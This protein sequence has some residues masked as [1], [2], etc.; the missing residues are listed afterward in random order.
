MLVPVLSVIMFQYR[1]NDAGTNVV[2][3]FQWC[4]RE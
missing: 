3:I 4:G 1:F 2:M